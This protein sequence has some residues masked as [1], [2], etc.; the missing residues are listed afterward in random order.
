MLNKV[1]NNVHYTVLEYAVSTQTILADETVSISELR[2]KPKEYFT[3]HAIAVLSNN[4]T[5]GYVIGAE[6]YETLLMILRQSQQ[7][8]TFEGRFRPTA[9]RLR[10]ITEKGAKLLENATEEQLG[11]FSE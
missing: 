7:L 1:L 4:R 2:K 9:E 11:S 10:E 5:A 6:A 8:E 3:D